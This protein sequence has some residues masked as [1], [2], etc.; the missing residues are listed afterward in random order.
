MRSSLACLL[1]SVLALCLGGS[2]ERAAAEP[3]AQAPTA[4]SVD[5]DSLL[6]AFS[7]MPGLEAE[8]VEEKHLSLLAQPLVSRGRLFFTSPGLLRRAVS[9]PVPSTVIITPERL[10]MEDASG[11]QSIDLSSRPD[12]R[13]FVE[14]LVWILAGNRQALHDAYAVTFVAAT[15]A[16]AQWTLTLAPKKEP[17]THLIATITLRGNGLHV[18]EVVVTEKTGDSSVT[19]ITRANP[20][21]KFDAAERK[22]LFGTGESKR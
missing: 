14:S 11:V 7:K 20:D 9:D 19:R 12:L 13:P 8:F 18:S 15:K 22:R 5:A 4:G 17:L 16:D 1:C 21:R 10:R 2:P 3:G 6:V